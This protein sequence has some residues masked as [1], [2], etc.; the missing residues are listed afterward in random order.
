MN[1]LIISSLITVKI[2]Y[3]TIDYSIVVFY[4]ASIKYYQ[5]YLN[6]AG[7][8]FHSTFSAIKNKNFQPFKNVLFLIFIFWLLILL[9]IR[10]F[11]KRLFQPLYFFFSSWL[12][13]YF[14]FFKKLLFQWKKVN[15]VLN[16]KRYLIRVNLT[17]HEDVSL[18]S[19]PFV[20]ESVDQVRFF[21]QRYPKPPISVLILKNIVYLLLRKFLYDDDEK[22]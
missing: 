5:Q 10:L 3:Y 12:F 18:V 13:H 15:M 8:F 2:L 6:V 14:Q 9:L 22:N 21:P 19:I 20:L 16:M 1:I 17:K 7:Y 11:E 4:T